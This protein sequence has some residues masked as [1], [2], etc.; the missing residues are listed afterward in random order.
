M[1]DTKLK[2][3]SSKPKEVT[4]QAKKEE[5]QTK[6]AIQK[7]KREASLEYKKKKLVTKVDSSTFKD[8]SKNDD[9]LEEREANRSNS[10]KIIDFNSAEAKKEEQEEKLKAEKKALPVEENLEN[11]EEVE[12]E[13]HTVEKPSKESVANR[14]FNYLRNRKTTFVELYRNRRNDNI[15]LVKGMVPFTTA[16]PHALVQVLVLIMANLTPVL[17]V[18]AS[19]KFS[20]ALPMYIGEVHSSVTANA[21]QASL[22][23]AG[24]GS[25]LQIIPLFKMGSRL[26][27][28]MGSSFTFM[29]CLCLIIE[30]LGADGYG[31]VICS[32]LI[33]GA[34]LFVL[35]FFAKYWIKYL[36]P[37]VSATVIISVG[38]G[39]VEIGV[40]HLVSIDQ[41][42]SL[43]KV[44]PEV[45]EFRYA[46]P[47]LI[48]GFVTL[49]T[50]IIWQG[51]VKGPLKEIYVVVGVIVGYI[52]SLIFNHTMPELHIMDF[53]LLNSYKTSGLDV[54]HFVH[55]SVLKFNFGATLLV[56][57]IYLVMATESI[58]DVMATSRTCYGSKPKIEEISGALAVDGLVS[59]LAS[60]LGT[61]PLSTSNENVAFISVSYIVNKS[62]MVI[63]SLIMILLSFSPAVATI[64]ETIPEAVLG[65]AMMLVYGY[66][67]M[68]GF[69]M[70][71]RAG[72]SKYNV[73]TFT[74]SLG[75][76]YGMSKLGEEFFNTTTF[77]GNTKYF[78]F[79][80]RNHEAMMFL[81]SLILSLIFK[82]KN[83]D[84][85]IDFLEVASQI[86]EAKEGAFDE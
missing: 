83:H 85:R 77:P 3:T 10:I 24:V 17:V 48:I 5:K 4:N 52:L 61:P 11:K 71:A 50:C 1:S 26:P 14:L 81:I 58:G 7:E 9:V 54:P 40:E 60:A 65:G 59:C 25:L 15:H 53:S 13:V 62:V 68:I 39:L 82:D 31:T 73:L 45:Y 37:I 55:P 28:M 76:G 23:C 30:S 19:V 42:I 49:I 27:T 74:L 16:L 34:V 22:L 18:M 20:S 78:G 43:S 51:T 80:L 41:V 70:F 36:K 47:F 38:L 35:S 32:C 21:I 33:G 84:D 63:S 6:K 56:V 2:K 69:R 67:L 86:S 8:S 29:G 72:F 79:F 46:W 75:I 12:K 44:V 64:L 66:V 57:V